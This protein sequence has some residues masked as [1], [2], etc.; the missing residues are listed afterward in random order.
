MW[1]FVQY[2]IALA[3]LKALPAMLY[4][5][6]LFSI[7]CQSARVLRKT[8]VKSNPYTALVGALSANFNSVVV[9]EKPGSKV[10]N[11]VRVEVFPTL[12]LIEVVTRAKQGMTAKLQTIT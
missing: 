8:A 2:C 10:G 9:C 1:L 12:P 6:I 5:M 7:R 11:P 4:L 3:A